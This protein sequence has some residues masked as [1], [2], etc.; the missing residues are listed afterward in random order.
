[1]NGLDVLRILA[2][3][4]GHLAAREIAAKHY[5]ITV[6]E[7][8]RSGLSIHCADTI[9]STLRS[10]RDELVDRIYG[11]SAQRGRCLYSITLKGRQQLAQGP[12][13]LAA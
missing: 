12:D 8:V 2:E 7:A 9:A 11:G 10:G 5:G 3:D 13:A 1:M 6:P 4:G